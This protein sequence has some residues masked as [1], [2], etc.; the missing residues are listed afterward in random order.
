VDLRQMFEYQ[1]LALIFGQSLGVAW[2]VQDDSLTSKGRFETTWGTCRDCIWRAITLSEA[3]TKISCLNASDAR[4]SRW[5]AHRRPAAGAAFLP[6]R[7]GRNFRPPK[8]ILICL[9]PPSRLAVIARLSSR[10][11]GVITKLPLTS[12]DGRDSVL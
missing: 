2:I 3:R 7:A 10:L 9:C 8:N 4:A 5:S 6:I 12:P 11:I 1:A